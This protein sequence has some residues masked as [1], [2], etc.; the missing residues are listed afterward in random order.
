M[1][2]CC[3]STGECLITITT[4]GMAVRVGI[5]LVAAT[6]IADALE[7]HGDRYLKRIYRETE[8]ADCRR[9][10]ELDPERLAARFAAKEA[11]IKALAPGDEP[12][13]WLDIEV[14]RRPTGAVELL[15][16]GRAATFAHDAG[17]TGFALSITHEQGIAAAVVV[18]EAR[19]GAD[20]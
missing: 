19:I 18:A 1:C 15:I 12:I 13:P 16:H 6:T 8:V 3:Q 2:H 14:R 10:G 7:A 4:D 9:N 17:I 11:A 20:R 5:D